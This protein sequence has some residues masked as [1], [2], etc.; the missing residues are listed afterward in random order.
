MLNLKNVEFDIYLNRVNTGVLSNVTV[1][2]ETFL[3]H[4]SLLEFNT[5]F[6]ILEH[7]GFHDS[8]RITARTL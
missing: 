1:L 7:D 8:N 4:L 6:N 5:K 3:D 2:M